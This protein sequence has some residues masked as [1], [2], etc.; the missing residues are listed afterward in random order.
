MEKKEQN[1]SKENKCSN[2]TIFHLD[3]KT[4]EGRCKMILL[5]TLIILSSAIMI[6]ANQ[7]TYDGEISKSISDELIDNFESGFF[8]SFSNEV[9]DASKVKFGKWQGTLRGCGIMKDG[10][11]QAYILEEGIKC[12]NGEYIEEIPSQDI[13]SYKGLSLS[14]STKGK[15]YDLLY[16]GSIIKNGEKCPEGKKSCGYIDTLKN[17]YCI[18]KD[19]KCPISYI[20]I[21]STPPT[22]NI[23]NIITVKGWGVNLYYSNTPSS[24]SLDFPYIVNSFKIADSTICA[25]PN[26]YYSNIKLHYLD[27]FV[28]K[29]SKNCVLTDYSQKVTVD[30]IR[31][32]PISEVDNYE[33][34]E[35]NRILEKIRNSKIKDYGFNIEKYRNNI[36]YLYGR[37]HFGF[38]KDCLDQMEF[39]RDHLV[40]IYGMA[41]N[42]KVYG[43]WSY[44]TIA[45]IVSSF[46][47]F[48]S[49]TSYFDCSKKYTSLE[50]LI[51][52]LINI[53]SSLYLLIYSCFAI[54][55][56]DF[57]QK[58]MTCS[59]VITNNNYNIMIYKLRNNGYLISWTFG[60]YI[61][62]FIFILI[63]GIYLFIL[64]E[65]K[66][67]WPCSNQTEN[68]LLI[69]EK[70]RPMLPKEDGKQKSV[71][72]LSNLAK[73]VDKNKSEKS[74]PK[75][76]EKDSENKS[77]KK[78]QNS[79]E[80]EGENKSGEN[81]NND[82]E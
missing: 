63:Y 27:A 40:Y 11:R 71:Q 41:D 53:S 80:K 35:E 23:E 70:E 29:F 19:A 50:T 34:Y 15:Y 8:M 77:E 31:Y 37:A 10:V 16:D 6:I 81:E 33:L 5:L 68:D 59:D 49:F 2:C 79:N 14:A 3:W 62:L 25:L 64:R 24:D 39:S 65:N 74:E 36:L 42:M 13:T 57:Y 45:T 61:A 20:K 17:I 58:E 78:D 48:F 69:S 82:I 47:N 30:K 67:G 9:P 7:I 76:P 55:Y 4:P 26:L 60:L 22:D 72:E 54:K 56:D 51:K 73:E 38:D 44:L 18:D 75:S 12:K 43:S 66:K 28:N 32:F 21:Q 52:F 1:E 46:S